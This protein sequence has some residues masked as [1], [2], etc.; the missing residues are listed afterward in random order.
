MSIARKVID[1][2]KPAPGVIESHAAVWRAYVAAIE[3]MQAIHNQPRTPR[4][5]ERGHWRR[6]LS[7]SKQWPAPWLSP[8]SSWRP[9]IVGIE[10]FGPRC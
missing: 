10:Q 1:K 7:V 9:M 6:K 3:A 4:S 5:R 8:G 2:V